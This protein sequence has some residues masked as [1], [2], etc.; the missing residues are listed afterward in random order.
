MQRLALAALYSLLTSAA[1]CDSEEYLLEATKADPVADLP[2]PEG[3]ETPAKAEAPA[4]DANEAQKLPAP[5]AAY[6][7][8]ASA[9][10]ECL[11]KC[12]GGEL[13]DEDQA[14][15]RLD[16]GHEASPPEAGVRRYVDCRRECADEAAAADCEPKC[17]DELSAALGES[18]PPDPGCLVPCLDA[19]TEC[20]S[21]CAEA[22][23]GSDAA[24]TCGLRCESEGARCLGACSPAAK[25][26]AP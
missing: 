25:R 4:M 10:A 19:L 23:G 6:P 13:S 7:N 17:R 21:K 24:A 8:D 3:E 22:K 18:T 16:C 1:A 26:A 9:R 15:C 12:A 14:T 11:A 2:P 20:E 5:E